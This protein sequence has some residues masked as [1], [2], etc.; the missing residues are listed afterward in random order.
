M[1]VAGGTVEAQFVHDDPYVRVGIRVDGL[2]V[3]SGDTVAVGFQGTADLFEIEIEWGDEGTFASSADGSGGEV[4][5]SEVDT[6][7]DS[8]SL[9][10][11]F[12]GPQIGS[13]DPGSALTLNGTLN[14]RRSPAP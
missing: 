12:D 3:R 5:F 13:L 11:R 4:H 1:A 9:G 14:A 10:V 2:S 7:R 8:E 6:T